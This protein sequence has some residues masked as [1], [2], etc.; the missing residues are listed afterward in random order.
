MIEIM[1][2]I[3][4]KAPASLSD[5][6]V[7][8]QSVL[9]SELQHMLLK[10]L[11]TVAEKFVPVQ[12]STTFPLTFLDPLLAKLHTTDPDARLLVLRIFQTLIDRKSNLDK[13]EQPSVEPRSDLV[14]QKPNFN[15][16]DNTFFIKHGEKIYREL[17][18]VLRS[19][20]V[21]VEFLEHLHT[22]TALLLL[23]CNSDDNIR[24]Q[25]DMVQEIQE[26]A[27]KNNN[28][29]RLSNANKFALHA[30]CISQLAVLS[31]VVR[32]PDIFEYKDRLVSLRRSL[33]PHLLPPLEI[34]YS[35]DIDPDDQLEQSLIDLEPV[36]AALKDC[37]RYTDKT[38]GTG[39]SQSLRNSR[40]NSP[41]HSPRNSWIESVHSV[42]R[43]PSSVSVSSI[44]VDV[45]SCASSPGILRRP[46]IVEVSFAEMK[47]ALAEPSLKDRE[48]EEKL[49]KE[50]Q[51]KFLT[52]T[53]SEL[54]SLTL[55]NKPQESLYQ[56]LTDI[57]GRTG[58]VYSVLGGE[59]GNSRKSSLSVDTTDIM[60]P[61]RP[62]VHKPMYEEYFPELFMY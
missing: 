32:L 33:V 7:D 3:L 14:A 19:E 23:E 21:S 4:G 16:Q 45:D 20:P 51:E 48:S 52:A 9:D 35:P 57:Y 56:C 12:F 60:S 41:R 8:P 5:S 53:F 11:L 49:R 39:G 54:C 13:L 18:S 28:S 29:L 37:G 24:L 2:F 26:L 43:R 25:M 38:G 58:S 1:M 6:Q 10:A 40:A 36:K 27:V 42:Q 22:T 47:R 30:T 44:T 61:V 46:P 34:E 17:V 62:E 50:L 31:F 55:A 59:G 15:K